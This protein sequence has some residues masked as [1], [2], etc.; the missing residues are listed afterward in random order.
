MEPERGFFSIRLIT[1]E[2]LNDGTY[3]EE[4]EE[5]MIAKTWENRRE[6]GFDQGFGEGIEL[7][8]GGA[9]QRHQGLEN[10]KRTDSV[11]EVQQY[12]LTGFNRVQMNWRM[13]LSSQNN[14]L[15]RPSLAVIKKEKLIWFEQ[16]N[17]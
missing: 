15:L 17:P 2:N 8:C 7:T 9:F 10:W 14:I 4:S 1:A 13:L 11:S 16:L 12:G 6:T 3:P 5:W